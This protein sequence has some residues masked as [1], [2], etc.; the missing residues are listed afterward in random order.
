MGAG[1]ENV[2][3]GGWVLGEAE[4]AGEGLDGGGVVVDDGARCGYRF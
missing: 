1:Q 2:S 4:P 3:L